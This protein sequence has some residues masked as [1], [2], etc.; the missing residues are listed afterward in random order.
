MIVLGLL[1]FAIVLTSSVMHIVQRRRR[2]DLR[3]RVVNGEVNLEAVGV[4]RLTIPREFLEKLPMYTYSGPEDGDLEKKSPQS[5]ARAYLTPNT[6]TE[7]GSGVRSASLFRRSSAPSVPTQPTRSSQAFS[8]PTCPI[9][10]DDFEQ[11]ETQVREL[12]CWHIFHPECVDTFLLNNSS[13]C[14]MCKKSVLPSGYCPPRITNVMV[15]RERM[16][17]RMRAQR[18]APGRAAQMPVSSPA[19]TQTT[20]RLRS[21]IGGAIT[22]R[23]V[24]SAP[25]HTPS[26]PS[27]IEMA[28]AT[29]APQRE[30]TAVSGSSNLA[31]AAARATGTRSGCSATSPHNRREWA[32]ERALTLL[33]DHHVP[34]SNDDEEHNM[35]LW[36]RG[37]QKVFPGFR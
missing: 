21:R 6:A 28:V 36:K 5:P 9:C 24:F 20:P 33:G 32:R 13:L 29:T 23:R 34:G 25:E 14:P 31:T 8:Q 7:A 27:D 3:Q 37:L 17:A 15:R 22:G 26:H 11:H 2:E 35:P 4:K 19:P 12:P 30:T 1:V 18:I 10:L 16:I